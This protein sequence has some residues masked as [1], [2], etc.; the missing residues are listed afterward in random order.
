MSGQA[1]MEWG[2]L[3]LAA[4]AEGSL[5]PAWKTFI[6][7]KFFV[8]IDRSQDDDPK[9]FRLHVSSPAEDGKA[10]L[11]ISEVRERLGQP[12]GDGVVALSGADILARLEDGAAIEVLLADTVFS[13]SR[14]RVAWLRS[15]INATRARIATRKELAA[16]APA[17]PFPVLVVERPAAQAPRGAQVSGPA[18]ARA[19]PAVKL[20]KLSPYIK[21]FYNWRVVASVLG[22]VAFTGIMIVVATMGRSP[23]EDKLVQVATAPTPAPVSAALPRLGRAA[24]PVEQV[25]PFSPAD[26]SFTVN[27]PGMV[28]EV[29]LSPDQV[30]R[31]ADMESHQYRLVVDDR[32]YA[33]EA[34]EYRE[35]PPPNINAAMDEVQ[36]T[37]VGSGTLIVTNSVPMRGATGREVRVRMPG[38]GERA[39]RYVFSGKKYGMVM[40][41]VSDGERS[42]KHIDAFLNSFQL[43]SPPAPGM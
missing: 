29:E 36:R 1:L 31:L 12:H 24:A 5:A 4:Q 37:I 2:E 13:I 14:K 39:A 10:A 32:S 28:E 40:V 9:N 38:G 15:G 22:F 16:A 3:A 43:N 34:S 30:S 7:T 41:T 8:A 35:N 17:A 25:V 26:N 6:K 18:P 27:V 19:R 42:A 33:M 11:T 21:S 20:P 23:D